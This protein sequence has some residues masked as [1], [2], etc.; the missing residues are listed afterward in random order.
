MKNSGIASVLCLLFLVLEPGLKAGFVKHPGK[1]YDAEKYPFVRRD[2]NGID[3]D[4]Q[5][6][7]DFY[8]RLEMLEKG[9]LRKINVVHIGD[10]HRQADWFSGSVRMALQKRFGSAG[11]LS[12]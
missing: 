9:E 4:Q 12:G 11:R 5:G 2:L 3:N 6:L 10:S 7:R 8:R 1:I